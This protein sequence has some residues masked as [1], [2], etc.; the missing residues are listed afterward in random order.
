[1]LV[2][3]VYVSVSCSCFMFMLVRHVRVG[4]CCTFPAAVPSPS[5]CTVAASSHRVASS[6]I[7]THTSLLASLPKA[8]SRT[9]YTHNTDIPPHTHTHTHNDIIRPRNVFS[10]KFSHTKCLSHTISETLSDTQT[11]KTCKTIS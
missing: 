5:R 8:T 2:F 3:H 7:L 10:F 11:G 4:L 6:V 9:H 1:M